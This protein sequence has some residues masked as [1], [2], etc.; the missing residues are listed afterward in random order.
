MG[1]TQKRPVSHIRGNW[2][3][4]IRGRHILRPGMVSLRCEAARQLPQALFF[5][6]LII[7]VLSVL[8]SR[9]RVVAFHEDTRQ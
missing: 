3:I 9:S 1:L 8:E 6:G 4:K 2:G 7:A 5:S